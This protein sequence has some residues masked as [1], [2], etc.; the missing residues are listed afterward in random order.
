MIK[1]IIAAFISS[2]FTSFFVLFLGVVIDE[3]AP[4]SLWDIVTLIISFLISLLI[5]IFLGIPLVIALKK[6]NKLNWLSITS[7]GFAIGFLL[8]LGKGLFFYYSAKSYYGSGNDITT[9]I[10][11]FYVFITSLLMG[12]IGLTSSAI[13]YKIFLLLQSKAK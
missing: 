10:G 3:S 5:N 11:W 8:N 9:M 2:V 12:V 6:F 7:I 1:L 4:K 13:F